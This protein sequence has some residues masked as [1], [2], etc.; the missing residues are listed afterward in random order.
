MNYR[1]DDKSR[2]LQ[3]PALM[4]NFKVLDEIFRLP[5]LPAFQFQLTRKAGGEA[6]VT[7]VDQALMRGLATAL[8]LV[9]R[10]AASF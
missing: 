7:T 6:V 3:Q 10:G 1:T 8:S 4:S 2:V 9:R 5:V